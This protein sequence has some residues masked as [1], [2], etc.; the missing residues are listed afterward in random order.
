MWDC[1]IIG[2]TM[3]GLALGALLAR[4]GQTVMVVERKGFPGGRASVWKRGGY[5]SSV[6]IQRVRY[7]KHGALA[8]ICRALGM[9]LALTAIDTVWVVDLDGRASKLPLSLAECITTDFF[10][11]FDRIR[12]LRILRDIKR[13]ASLEEFDEVTLE[14]WLIRNGTGEGLQRYFSLLACE[15][16][17]CNSA[18]KVSAGQF[19]ASLQK[20]LGTGCYLGYPR[21]GWQPIIQLF[22]R[23]ISRRGK[24]LWNCQVASVKVSGGRA[25]G[26]ETATGESIEAR[27]VVSTLPCQHLFAVL[28]PQ[29]TH[30]DFVA[31]CKSRKPSAGVIMDFALS[32]RVTKD[33]G[34]WVFVDPLSYGLFVSNVCHRHAPPGK[35]LATFVSPCSVEEAKQPERTR[36]LEVKIEEGL[37]RIFRDFDGSVEWKRCRVMGMLDS[38]E[39]NIAQ[40][41]KD[42]PGYRVPKVEG[43]YLVGDFTATSGVV[44]EVEYESVLGCYERMTGEEL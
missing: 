7:G 32:H 24:L 18:D 34:L 29:A 8:K 38:V 3:P 25:C 20:V 14:E 28:S 43:L 9:D 42:R 16:T 40:R 4:R 1:I 27:S 5:T 26:I 36:A 37:R 2:A 12:A 35:Q 41:D 11:F 30:R 6:G 31:L 21:W 19:L 10:S 17:H 23:E 33:R 44:G 15:A 39:M 13:S 22:Q